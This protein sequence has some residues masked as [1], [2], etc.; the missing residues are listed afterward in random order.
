MTPKVPFQFNQPR[1]SVTEMWMLTARQL[2]WVTLQ[3]PFQL[4]PFYGSVI[5]R[6][7]GLETAARGGG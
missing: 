5:L 1:G 4:D 7:Y 2:H 6:F 3:V